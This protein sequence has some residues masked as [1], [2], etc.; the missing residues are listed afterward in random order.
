M[1][2]GRLRIWANS[3][4]IHLKTFS[5]IDA[6]NLL[7]FV[8]HLSSFDTKRPSP[9]LSQPCLCNNCG[10]GGRTTLLKAGPSCDYMHNHG[11]AELSVIAMYARFLAQSHLENNVT[12]SH[13]Y[14]AYDQSYRVSN[15]ALWQWLSWLL[16]FI[17]ICFWLLFLW[18]FLGFGCWWVLFESNA[19]TWVGIGA[20]DLQLCQLGSSRVGGNWFYRLNFHFLYSSPTISSPPPLPPPPSRPTPY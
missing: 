15:K 3:T 13:N 7:H 12:L 5:S 14:I 9:P 19:L 1:Q 4:N 16:K 11:R 17:I 18:Q 8:L 10:G 6:H 2:N 20:W